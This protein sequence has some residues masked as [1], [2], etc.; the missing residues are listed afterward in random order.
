[1]GAYT[2]SFKGEKLP[3]GLYIY[4]LSAGNKVFTKKMMLLK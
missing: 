1:P 4:R 3:S 2:V